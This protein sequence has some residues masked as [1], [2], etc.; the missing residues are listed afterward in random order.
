MQK[1]LCKQL[2]WWLMSGSCDFFVLIWAAYT[3]LFMV[4]GAI[5]VCPQGEFVCRD[6]KHKHLHKNI[7][8]EKKKKF[9]DLSRCGCKEL[10]RIDELLSERQL[11]VC[12]GTQKCFTGQKWNE[13]QLFCG[14]LSC[15][16]TGLSTGLFIFYRSVNLGGASTRSNPGLPEC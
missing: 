14:R 6:L 16:W 1:S 4:T 5:A 10:N 9:I 8:V 3:W 11:S 15:R 7:T 2:L 12:V 13:K